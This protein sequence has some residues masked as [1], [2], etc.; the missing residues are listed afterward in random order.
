M[1][2]VRGWTE[3]E[4][5]GRE[6]V[7][8]GLIAKAVRMSLRPL[9]ATLNRT[10]VAAGVPTIS[11]EPGPVGPVLSPAQTTIV[12]ATWTHYV[13]NELFPYLAQTFVDAAGA[14]RAGTETALDVSVPPVTDSYA[15]SYLAAAANRLVNVG[16][17]VWS[18]VRDQLVEGYSAGEST[19]Q[20]A[21]RVRHVAGFTQHRAVA[22]ARTE[23]VAAANAGSLAQL[24]LAGFTD[25]ECSKRWMA[26]EDERTRVAHH[27]ADGQTVGLNQPFSVGGEGLQFPG[28]PLG[29]PD[30][31]IQCRCTLE[32]VFGDDAEPEHDVALTAAGVHQAKHAVEKAFD[33]LKHPRAP[34]GAGHGGEFVKKGLGVGQVQALT[35]IK[36]N[37]KVVYGTKYAHNAVVA[38]RVLKNG[39]HQ[40]LRWND[41]SEKFELW[42]NYGVSGSPLAISQVLGKGQTYQK[43]GKDDPNGWTTPGGKPQQGLT[44]WE[45]SLLPSKD[46]TEELQKM[47]D[48]EATPSKSKT[49][50]AVPTHGSSKTAINT[51][52]E[53]LDTVQWDKLPLEKKWSL[54]QIAMD[55]Y[56]K[57]NTVPHNKITSIIASNIKIA[58]PVNESTPRTSSEAIQTVKGM[59]GPEFV[60]FM[61]EHFGPDGDPDFWNYLDDAE[62][63]ALK[64]KALDIQY[65][66]GAKGFGKFDQSYLK[67]YGQILDLEQGKVY[68][69]T[70]A[71]LGLAAELDNMTT[72][73]FKIWL[74]DNVHQVA[75]EAYIPEK[76]KDAIW[77]AAVAHGPQTVKIFNDLIHGGSGNLDTQGNLL[78]DTLPNTP[79]TNMGFFD[80]PT[81]MG[82]EGE[83]TPTP[84]ATPWPDLKN[85]KS[86]G[87]TVGTHG[88]QIYYDTKTGKNY[89]FKPTPA[90]LDH[91]IAG[92][93]A[94]SKLQQKLGIAAPELRPETIGG[95]K[96]SLQEWIPSSP[97]FP[98]KFDPKQLSP[99]EINNLVKAQAFDWLVSNHDSH[100]ANFIV[101]DKTGEVLA[102]DKTQSFKFFPYD[103]LSSTYHPNTMEQQPVY[104]LLW[105]A[106]EQGKIDIPSPTNGNAG[107]VDMDLWGMQHI[108]DDEY[109]AILKPYA[110][111]AAKRGMLMNFPNAPGANKSVTPVQSGKD[112][113]Y[114]LDLAV[115]R[116]N[117][118]LED[119]QSFYLKEVQK[120]KANGFDGVNPPSASQVVPQDAPKL[121]KS[122]PVK[123]NTTF[124]Y[125]T[126]H[127][128]GVPIAE[129]A[130]PNGLKQQL[131]W[132]G[133]NYELWIDDQTGKFT[134]A[135]AMGKGATYEQFSKND[136]QGGWMTPGTPS[137]PN[138]PTPTISKPGKLPFEPAFQKPV[139]V[140]KVSK[141]DA[142]TIQAQ[143]GT[144]GGVE[145]NAKTTVY[146]KF[147]KGT[148][149]GTIT[150]KS[151]APTTFKALALTVAEYNQEKPN[152]QHLNALQ[153]LK[154]IDEKLTPFGVANQN[155]YEKKIVEWLGTAGGKK[156]APGFV[157]W[158]EETAAQTKKLASG[159]VGSPGK[160][161]A[162]DDVL[163]IKLGTPS[164]APADFPVMSLQSAAAMHKK[165]Q[166]NTPWNSEQVVAIQKYTGSYYSEMNSALRHKP[167]YTGSAMKDAYH[168]Q[169]AMRPVPE[170][171]IVHRGTIIKQFGVSSV[172]QLQNLVGQTVV[173]RGFMSTSVGGAAAFSGDIALT[174]QVPKGTPGAYVKSKSSHPSENEFILAAGTK[175]QIIKVTNTGSYKTHVIVRV[176]P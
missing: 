67:P 14:V 36:I 105:Q 54:D 172:A 33:E 65:D 143:Y 8:E 164:T 78:P 102:I 170:D 44:E 25:E 66:P 144:I 153:V 156:N 158:A 45:K 131:R 136:A 113:E 37:T 21:A 112:V 171:F 1:P 88:A 157:N 79:A 40:E 52:F 3:H 55:Q 94:V 13:D 18:T 142:A 137:Q 58:Y 139:V 57:G 19:H 20:L 176:V 43:Y 24:Q 82:F 140:P 59:N 134:F 51:Y 111:A 72:E 42:S 28:D 74:Y 87:D 117:H 106:F 108:P 147:K 107:H 9:S 35:P 53:Q 7:F 27:V 31:I 83:P 26:T 133:K 166:G 61:D 100:A 95:V 148:S 121:V 68:S 92:D 90:K 77:N 154:I 30:N 165:M 159:P 124:I 123:I 12:T 80:E 38:Q 115:S 145:T 84:M 63:K 89:L 32:Y 50:L 162:V 118:L 109:R 149:L 69:D 174:I 127:P 138:V 130:L 103:Q 70:S 41:K 114:F 160:I 161:Y 34:K 16:D 60:Q 6:R 91:T 64:D 76:D 22:V 126:S 96:G 62:K 163:K 5:L 151:T 49:P 128:I 10:L 39:T 75:W 56:H 97:A 167:S 169:T 48:L 132:N 46:W 129:R 135:A 99:A 120:R 101:S 86:T 173:D 125:K 146:E 93:V 175:F 119:F 2:R 73:D 98:G 122:Q 141:F 47:K 15:V 85:L 23:V 155:L 104:N 150:L 4:L 168:L 116:K 81:P 11:P 152:S 71:A 29:R 110:E 17:V